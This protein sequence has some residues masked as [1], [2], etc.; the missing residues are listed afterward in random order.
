MK[1]RALLNISTSI[2]LQITAM[3]S[4]LVIPRAILHY[5]GS[6]TNGLIAS[7]NQF[8]GYISLLEGGLGSVILAALYSPLLKRDNH[9]ISAVLNASMQ[10]FKKIAY[11][12]IL[13]CCILG[14]FYP[15][16][17]SSSFNWNYIFSITL[18]LAVALFSQYYF[19]IAYKL[20]LQADQKVY[21]VYI[22]QILTYIVNLLL[23]L[24][25]L[26]LFPSIHIV[27]LVSAL[28]YAIQPIFLQYYVKRHYQL[29]P[30]E[31]PDESALSQRWDCF[32]QNLAYFI[33]SN[34]DIAILTLF[35][36][37]KMVSVYSVYFMVVK[38]VRSL[39]MSVSSAFTP[40]LGR[41]LAGDDK[42]KTDRCIDSFELCMYMV[43]TI[44][45]GCCLSM[46]D[47][48]VSLYT[49]GINDANYYQPVFG[50][51]LILS[52]FVYCVREPY[53]ETVYSK[54]HFK[55]TVKSAYIEAGINIIISVCLVKKFG[56]IG[57]AAGTLAGMIV[58][59]VYQ[60]VYI[61]K[62]IVFR[63]Y[64]NSFKSAGISAIV[65]ISGYIVTKKIFSIQEVHVTE[66]VRNGI[67][68][69]I[70]YLTIC[71]IM[72]LLFHRKQT[73]ML[74]FKILKK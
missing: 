30:E 57:V 49:H 18:I 37:L 16:F 35:L 70:I 9:K 8:L 56:L 3:I 33:H 15:V 64:R 66:W 60:I 71:V 4:G 42:E 25:V 27:K 24:G 41:C 44:V 74:V 50:A 11:V 22:L 45:F 58:R 39:I 54:G 38:S 23:T 5:F 61:Q 19:A 67:F 28:A 1:R 2:L 43:A 72:N 40:I 6:E 34:T 52:E 62:H 73:C 65:L 10:F 26:F 17:I 48:F 21:I 14:V 36:S 47:S 59:M 63:P 12:F 32:G 53:I 46:L 13:Y 20:L 69:F 55:Q 31:K 7:I 51:L 29:Y 68:S